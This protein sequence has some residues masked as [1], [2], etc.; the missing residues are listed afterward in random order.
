MRSNQSAYLLAS[1]STQ[2]GIRMRPLSFRNEKAQTKV[3]ARYQIA[4]GV[5]GTDHVCAVCA[6]ARASVAYATAAT[7]R[8]PSGRA[9]RRRRRRIAT[10]SVHERRRRGGVVAAA[11]AMAFHQRARYHLSCCA[12]R[13]D[14]T[15]TSPQSIRAAAWATN[16]SPPRRERAACTTSISGRRFTKRSSVQNFVSGYTSV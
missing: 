10:S 6:A 16:C 4:H 14:G 11:L 3:D 12:A 9:P 2:W 13:R 7:P 1:F 8:S 15:Q 5:L